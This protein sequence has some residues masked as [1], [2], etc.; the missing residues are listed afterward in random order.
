MD[1]TA[2]FILPFEC[3]DKDVHHRVGGKCASLGSMTQAGAA[4]PPGFAVTTDAYRAMLAHGDLR[5][6][7]HAALGEIVYGDVDSEEH[8]SNAIRSLIESVP[9][10]AAI[11]LAIRAAYAALCTTTGALAGDLPVAVRSSATAE[12]LPGASFAGQ[13]DTFLWVVGADAVLAHVRKCWSSLYTARAI[14]Y[15]HDKGFEH[16]KV[17]MAVAVQK[18]VNARVAGV[19]MTL[20]PINGD[21]SKVVIDASWGLGESV[22]GGTVTP[23][24]FHVD[25]VIHEITS[26]KISPKTSELVP[27]FAN[28]CVVHRAVDAARQNVACL[29]DAEVV[30]VAKTAREMEKY[31]GCPQDIEWALD[32]A[33]AGDNAGVVLLQSRPET[34][35]SQKAAAAKPI[36]TGVMGVLGTLLNPLKVKKREE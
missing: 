3:C 29:T 11:E 25:K 36:E 20:N 16:E 21:R 22:V 23:D 4:V 9:I 5:A 10:P 12:D 26:R 32:G 2:L 13:Q 7:I 19:A 34:V 28:R 33:G 27:D 18:M 24:N 15:R 14:A 1:T 6:G 30:A 17:F 8:A 35:W 31:Y